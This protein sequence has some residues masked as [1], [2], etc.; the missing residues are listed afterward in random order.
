MVF[1]ESGHTPADNWAVAD[2]LEWSYIA[3]SNYM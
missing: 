3:N 1:W 2:R